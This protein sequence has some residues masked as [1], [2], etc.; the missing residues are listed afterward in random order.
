VIVLAGSPH[1]A[2]TKSLA[3]DLGR[4]GFIVF[5][6]VNSMDDEQLVLSLGCRDIRPLHID[7]LDTVGAE[8]SVSRFEAYLN[9][10]V[11]AFQGAHPHHLH[12]AGM[13]LVPDSYYPTGP[14]EMISADVWSDVLNL[15]L[16]SPFITTKLFIRLLRAHQARLL[17]LTPSITHS[18][19]P[20]FHAPEAVAV[21][22][23][24][25]F[26]TSLRR[27]LRPLH[28]DVSQIKLGTFDLSAVLGRQHLQAVNGAR[29]DLVSWPSSVRGAYGRLYA[30]Q[31]GKRPV[32]GS[33]L[34]ELHHAVF[35]V[36]AREDR[37]VKLVRVGGGSLVYDLIG[38]LVPDGV[39][40]WMLNGGRGEEV[41][42]ARFGGSDG[43]G[44]EGSVDWEK[45]DR[46]G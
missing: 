45:V 28:V 30:A 35:D 8:A 38:R 13:V 31:E 37:L 9:F 43:S 27:E 39:V 5:L 29:A 21:A 34:R 12:L 17:V 10:P 46:A 24:D 4:R 25:S 22:A 3:Q 18:L 2:I 40:E 33:P 20:S 23:L 16:I 26:T 6:V 7:L 15:R 36:L 42:V 11:T 41:A 1:D 19:S 32:K 44:S 14:I